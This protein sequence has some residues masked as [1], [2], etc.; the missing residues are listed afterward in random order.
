MRCT[1][2]YREPVEE[3]RG[4]SKLVAHSGFLVNAF[5]E[6]RSRFC[7]LC[8]YRLGFLR[9]FNMSLDKMHDEKFEN[10]SGSERLEAGFGEDGKAAKTLLFKMDI[11]YV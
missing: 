11:R 3:G 7:F 9:L 8:L 4:I 1:W 5:L 6:L 10:G 2:R